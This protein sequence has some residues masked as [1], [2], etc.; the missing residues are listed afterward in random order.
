MPDA[1]LGQAEALL[2]GGRAG[3][4]MPLLS[5][6]LAT[7]GATPDECRAALQLR[8]QAREALGDAAGALRDLEHAVARYPQD[9]RLQN[10][11]G[12]LLADKGDV[13]APSRRCR[14][15]S[16]STRGTRAPGTISPMRCA[17]AAD[18]P[19]G[20]AARTR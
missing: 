10:A 9:P 20:A 16:S 3:E 2:R 8:A 12:I 11:L 19:R 1:R 17:A 6:V 7:V 15:R 18:R 14:R 5:A 4:A 13:A